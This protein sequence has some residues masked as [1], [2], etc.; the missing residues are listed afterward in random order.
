[1]KFLMINC[2][3]EVEGAAGPYYVFKDEGD[4]PKTQIYKGDDEDVAYSKIIE[5]AGI[6]VEELDLFSFMAALTEGRFSGEQGLPVNDA[7]CSTC[8]KQSTNNCPLRVW[9]RN[10]KQEGQ[11]LNPMSGDFCSHYTVEE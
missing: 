3:G 8:G 10:E 1:M 9:G 6:E 4:G 11:N 2:G 7:T 5:S